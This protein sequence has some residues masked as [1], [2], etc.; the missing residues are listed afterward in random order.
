[1]YVQ[2]ITLCCNIQPTLQPMTL[3]FYLIYTTETLPVLYFISI[4]FIFLALAVNGLSPNIPF[5]RSRPNNVSFNVGETATL[6]CSVSDLQTRFVSTSTSYY[7]V[8]DFYSNVANDDIRFLLL[9]HYSLSV[10]FYII[11]YMVLL[12]SNFISCLFIFYFNTYNWIHSNV[13]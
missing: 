5:F 6:F 4:Y 8:D 1:M 7:V 9:L 11:R 3:F 13:I 12:F 10:F 2:L